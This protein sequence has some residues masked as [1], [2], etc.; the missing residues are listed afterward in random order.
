MD[1]PTVIE[2]PT[3]VTHGIRRV[4]PEKIEACTYRKSSIRWGEAES[5]RIGDGLPSPPIRSTS[6]GDLLR[7]VTRFPKYRRH[8]D[9]GLRANYGFHAN[10]RDLQAPRNPCRSIDV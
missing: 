7:E 2:I 8:S 10:N 1:I 4:A 3:I 5:Q 6:S 9:N